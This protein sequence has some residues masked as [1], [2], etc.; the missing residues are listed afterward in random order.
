MRKSIISICNRCHKS[1]S[2]NDRLWRYYKFI[3]SQALSSQQRSR[4]RRLHTAPF[5][6]GMCLVSTVFIPA[7]QVDR[8]LTHPSNVIYRIERNQTSWIGFV[9][10]FCLHLSVALRVPPVFIPFYFCPSKTCKFILFWFCK[11]GFSLTVFFFYYFSFFLCSVR[12]PSRAD[13][14]PLQAENKI[15]FQIETVCIEI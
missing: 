1:V 15:V 2:W 5:R 11:T 12:F 7:K 13:L 4:P 6:R 8:V 3:Y 14:T 10:V 9:F